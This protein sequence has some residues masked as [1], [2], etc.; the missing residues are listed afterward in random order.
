[1]SRLKLWAIVLVASIV[2]LVS[3]MSVMDDRYDHENDDNKKNWESYEKWIISVTSISIGLSFFG[4]LAS[5]LPPDRSM[6][7]ESPL[8]RFVFVRVVV[9]V[10][11]G[12]FVTKCTY[13]TLCTAVLLLTCFG[14]SCVFFFYMTDYSLLRIL[15][16]RDA[17]PDGSE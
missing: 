12:F 2:S 14:G 9:S 16:C 6:K 4:A 15:G 11:P 5:F 17:C 1:M 13:C 8:V 3:L 10:S 7:L